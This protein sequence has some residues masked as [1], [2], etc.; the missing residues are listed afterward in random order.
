[1]VGV[2]VELGVGNGLGEREQGGG[3]LFCPGALV[4]KG[5]GLELGGKVIVGDRVGD[6]G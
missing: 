4:G 6:G 5:L 1:M 2:R 3:G